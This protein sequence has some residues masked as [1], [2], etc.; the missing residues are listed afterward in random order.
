LPII[1]RYPNR[2]LYNTETKQYITLDELAELIRDGQELEVIDNANGDDLTV[3][4]MT[5]VLFE[6]VKKQAGF[7]PRTLL[8]GLIQAGGH[9]SL[10][11]KLLTGLEED[12][13]PAQPDADMITRV[14]EEYGVAT[15]D[16]MEK[17]VEQIDSLNS[18]LDGVLEVQPSNEAYPD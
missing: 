9:R 1:K 18:R 2:K 15:R 6:Q 13:E 11:D 5:Q 7:L 17:L 12:R 8:A 14:L 3:L 10:V 16:E 4:T